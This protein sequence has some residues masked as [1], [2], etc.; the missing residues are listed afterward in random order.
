LA[1]RL[2]ELIQEAKNFKRS[3]FALS[4]QKTYRSQLRRFL[5][6]CLDFDCVPVPASQETLL[7][8]AAYL[9]CSLSASSIP[10]YLN[11]IRL[12]HLEAGLVN[13]LEGNFELNMLK[14]GIRRVKG[15]PPCQKE[16]ITIEILRQM[17]GH[18]ELAKPAD[19]SFWSVALIAFFG[20]L[21]KS[22]V[23]PDSQNFDAKKTL[24]RSDV[25]KLCL[26]SFVLQCRHSK[27]VQFEKKVLMLPYVAC[28][29]LSLCPVRALL[30]HFGAS[31]LGARRPL[32]NY[33]CMGR[34]CAMTQADFVSRLKSLL[35][36]V[37]VKA[38]DYSAHS[39]RRG[40][41][42]YAF[43]IGMSPLQIKLRGDWGSDAYE[44]YIFISSGATLT[45]A[46]LLAGGVGPV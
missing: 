16:P 30:A 10:N 35:C 17:Y 37:S 19:L 1:G 2:G 23:L 36:K 21:R 22:S 13:P 29:D 26:S 33:L 25:S 34:E 39:F 20:F 44:R 11:V 14:R 12:L 31:P 42:S 32:F 18:L 7:C 41:A 3:Y 9:A 27:V 6:F 43:T 46:S 38:A 5:Q 8:Y 4:T 28:N 45:V 24:L 40:G 15:V